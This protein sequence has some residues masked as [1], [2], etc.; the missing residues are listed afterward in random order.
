[1]NYNLRGIFTPQPKIYTEEEDEETELLQLSPS[2][3]S[4]SLNSP[5]EPLL[6]D[7]RRYDT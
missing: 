7:K 6:A 3:S 4:S 1:M 2:S 5:R